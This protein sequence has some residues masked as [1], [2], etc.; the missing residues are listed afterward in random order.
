MQPTETKG[1]VVHTPVHGEGR[2]KTPSNELLKGRFTRIRTV[3]TGLDR[4]CFVGLVVCLL[5]LTVVSAPSPVRARRLAADQANAQKG[6]WRRL[7]P[8][9]VKAPPKPAGSPLPRT[10]VSW[11]DGPTHDATYQDHTIHLPGG[12]AVRVGGPIVDGPAVIRPGI[13]YVGDNTDWVE[14]W[15]LTSD[16]ELWAVHVPN[17]VMTTP[18]AVKAGGSR[19]L[20][21]V[22]LG[23]NG[24]LGYRSG[25]GWIRGTGYNAIVAFNARTGALVWTAQT[26]G[27][28]MATPVVWHGRLYEATGAGNLVALS[29]KTGRVLWKIHLGGFDSMSSPALSGHLLFFATNLYL[30]NYP[31][32][33]S[34][35]WAVNLQRRSVQW[36]TALPVA[37]GLSDC[38]PAVAAGRVFIAGITKIGEKDRRPWLTAR[39]FALQTTTGRVLWSQPL[40]SGSMSLDRE[41]V[42][43]PAVVGQKVFVASPPAHRVYAFSLNGHLNWSTSL[44]ADAATGSPAIWGHTVVWATKRGRLVMLA[45]NNGRFLSALQLSTGAFGPGS[46]LVVNRTLVIPT[47]SGWFDVV[48]LKTR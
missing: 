32:T 33:R 20:V 15:N 42:G 4:P 10:W 45:R 6:S 12:R 1:F 30:S 29:V 7:P 11:A 8:L 23:N 17:M 35:L 46:P 13:A 16:T 27:E 44:G 3:R 18:L 2:G 31:A 9:I 22:G 14:A 36:Q 40:G 38:S 19:L 39:L 43:I 41:E 21:I 34:V 26:V 48:A 5:M 24:F 47:L 28:D 37:S 25:Q